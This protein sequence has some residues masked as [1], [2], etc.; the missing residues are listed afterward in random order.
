MAASTGI[1]LAMGGIVIANN[2][3]VN[4]QPFWPR[5]AKVALATGILALGLGVLDKASP[6]L[7]TGLAIIAF[8]TAMVTP[9]GA[10]KSPLESLLGYA[11]FGG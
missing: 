4:K 9:F 7:A 6:E 8:I 2:T 11:G 5:E 3:I 10:R 1:V